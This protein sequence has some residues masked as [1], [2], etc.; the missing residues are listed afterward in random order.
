SAVVPQRN[1]PN[2]CENGGR[3]VNKDG[4][5]YNYTC[6]ASR[7]TPGFTA[8]KSLND[9]R[10]T[11]CANGGTCPSNSS[12]KKVVADLP[13]SNALTTAT[14]MTVLTRAAIAG[15]ASPV[16]GASSTSPGARRD[17][18]RVAVGAGT[19]RPRA[20][21]GFACDCD[22]GWSGQNCEINTDDCKPGY[23]L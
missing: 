18:A 5:G 11:G 6:S 21:G 22:A 15:R 19:C 2:P 20:G 23:C 12:G 13:P 3:C 7:A 8:R 4:F 16:A 9:C 10:L 1:N 14:P 17:P